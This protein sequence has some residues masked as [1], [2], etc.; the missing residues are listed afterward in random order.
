MKKDLWV[1]VA[2]ATES[3]LY[4]PNSAANASCV[5]TNQTNLFSDYLKNLP[6]D[7]EDYK[8]TQG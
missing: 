3:A 2:A 8:D 4:C 5:H 1:D 7:S 6:E